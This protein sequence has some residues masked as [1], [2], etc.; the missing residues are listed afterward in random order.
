VAGAIVQQAAAQLRSPG[1]LP[2]ESVNNEAQAAKAMT[3]LLSSVTL[4]RAQSR[5]VARQ[6]ESAA[7]ERS[8]LGPPELSTALRDLHPEAAKAFK[9]AYGLEFL[10]RPSEADLR[11]APRGPIP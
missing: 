8:P 6:I 3:E 5:E 4:S 1:A 2:A 9:N 11:R 10:E 7:F